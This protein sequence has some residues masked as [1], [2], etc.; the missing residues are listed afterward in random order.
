MGN[1]ILEN[2]LVKGQ[3]NVYGVQKV[4]LDGVKLDV[5]HIFYKDTFWKVKKFQSYG[6]EKENLLFR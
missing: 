5:G 2:F 4:P 6:I 3:K 1:N